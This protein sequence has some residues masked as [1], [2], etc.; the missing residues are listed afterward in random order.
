VLFLAPRRELITQTS[1]KLRDTGVNHGVILAGADHLHDVSAHAQVASLDTLLSRVLRQG[2]LSELPNFTMVLIDEA[3]LAVTAKRIEL[4][5]RWPNAIRIGLTAT[6]IRKDG[7]ALGVLFDRLIGVATISELT[8]AGHLVPARYFS[9]SEPD[10]KRVRITAGEFNA[11]DLDAVVNRPSL[12]GDVVAHWLRHAPDRRTV[13]FCTSVPHSIAVAE[14][15]QR[16]GVAAEHVDAGTPTDEREEMFARF[17]RGDTQVLTNCFL[18]S[19]GFDLPVLS[20]VVLARADTVADAVP[21]DDRPRPS[22]SRRQGGLPS[23]R[24]FGLRPRARLRS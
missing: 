18:A 9:L 11:K 14:A 5:D 24:P 6:P 7:R 3:H 4:L 12:V 2:K 10:L 19:Y 15:F 8:E 23:A 13:V 21:A 17:R 1:N 22:S 20:C 16:A